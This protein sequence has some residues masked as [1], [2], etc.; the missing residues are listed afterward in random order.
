[1]NVYVIEMN[2]RHY[3]AWIRTQ[4]EIE[5]VKHNNLALLD[6]FLRNYENSFSGNIK[7]E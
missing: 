2:W 4:I 5:I 6:K 1:M 3:C 7:E